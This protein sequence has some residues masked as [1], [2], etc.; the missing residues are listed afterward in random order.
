MRTPRLATVTL[1]LIAATG[2]IAGCG[3]GSSSGGAQPNTPAA[4][5]NGT[6]NP[7]AATAAVK[8]LYAEFFNA[9]EP[10]A[11]GLLEDGPSLTQAIKLAAKIKG[12]NSESAAVK[13]VTFPDAND[14]VVSYALSSNG[15]VVLADATGK[16]VYVNGKWL[17]AKD[18]FCT[19]VG[20]GNGGKPVPG[21]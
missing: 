17:F 15:T 12:K 4:Q 8:Q 1:S 6:A 7:Q 10:T 21:C 20:L 3:G 11:V 9:P 16:A 5:P 14:A 19:L 18:T 13:K 2:L